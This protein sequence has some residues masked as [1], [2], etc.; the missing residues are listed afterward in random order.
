M[1]SL[2]S[3]AHPGIISVVSAPQT[4]A[5]QV[6]AR[7]ARRDLWLEDL[8]WHRETYRESKFRWW[9]TDVMAIVTYNTWGRVD[10]TTLEHLRWLEQWRLGLLAFAAQCRNAM[11]APLREAQ[12]TFGTIN[13]Q[14]I[15]DAVGLTVLECSTTV[16]FDTYAAAADRVGNAQVQRVQKMVGGMVFGNP[17]ILIFELKQLWRMYQTAD[18]VHEDTLCD[19]VE[20]LRGTRRLEDIAGAAGMSAAG[21]EHRVADARA[22]RGGP[23]DPRR[24]PAQQF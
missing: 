22:A 5:K 7:L 23:G 12:E 13:W 3:A 15:A 2:A 17:L 20:E 1:L 10:F 6:S 8:A 9:D 4:V 21:L 16:W 11:A 18:N 24:I 19:L 14:P